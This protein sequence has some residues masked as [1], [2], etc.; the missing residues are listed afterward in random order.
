MKRKTSYALHPKDYVPV[1]TTRRRNLLAR[2]GLD[3]AEYDRLLAE[4]G[5]GCA[6]CG[7]KPKKYKHLPVDHDHVTGEVRWILCDSCN[8][9]LGGFKD[10]V[11]LLEIAIEYLA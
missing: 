6:I 5:G 2:F 3:E 11:D 8:T 9:A 1:G 4:Q 7:T 10:R